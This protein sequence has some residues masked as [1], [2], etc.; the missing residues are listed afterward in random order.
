MAFKTF[1]SDGKLRRRFRRLIAAAALLLSSLGS[2]ARAVLWD[3]GGVN[4]EWIEP[5]NWQFN[6]LPGTADVA[7]ITNDTATITGVTPPTVSG[8]EVGLGSMSGG[9]VMTGGVNPAMLNVVNNV[10]VAS[11]GSLTI[12]TGGPALSTV[13]AI[14]MT[15]AGSTSVLARGRVNLTG[16][17]TQSAG[18][19]SLNG[20]VIDAFSVIS[21][22][23]TFNATGDINANVTIGNGVGATATLAPGA[24]LEIDGNLKL[25]PDSRLEVEFRPGTGGGVFDRIDV[26]GTI[27][28]GGV[29]D[30][31]I[32]SGATPVE[33]A[34][35]TILSADG[36]FVS[37]FD[38]IV[39][40]PAGDGSWRPFID[41]I[42]NG[43]NVSYSSLRGN[44]NKD[45]AVDELDVEMFA[46]A[47]RDPN[48]YYEQFIVPLIGAADADMADMDGDFVNTF[49][50]IPLFLEAVSQSGGNP[51]VAFARL[52]AVLRGVPEPCA[53][54]LAAIA[55]VFFRQATRR[56]RRRV[57]GPL[58]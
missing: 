58:T 28:L 50:D 43:I 33:G 57:R 52:V 54:S 56:R 47:I 55:V 39:G 2:P 24:L 45:G 6:M 35:Y 15:T 29:L 7:T 37:E 13:K 27:T 46:W 38:D 25:A 23:G 26:T 49:A 5:A 21:Q 1:N 42:T 40:L 9:L 36:G 44:M 17:L 16:Q 19:L 10:A 53:G 8:V 51:E 32:L 41:D 34:T 22:A 48:S 20:G 18:T 11:A 4:S 30:L 12:G 14:N 31:S 3:G